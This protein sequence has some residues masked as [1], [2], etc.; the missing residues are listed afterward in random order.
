MWILDT[1]H[2]SLLQRENPQ[3]IDRLLFHQDEPVVITI[4][5]AEEQ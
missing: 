4:V 3:L 5:T 1:D 2:L